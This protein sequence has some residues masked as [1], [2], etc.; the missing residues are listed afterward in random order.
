MIIA[1]SFLNICSLYSFFDFGLKNK[2]K[3]YAE[4]TQKMELF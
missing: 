4:K 3:K 1:N 2:H